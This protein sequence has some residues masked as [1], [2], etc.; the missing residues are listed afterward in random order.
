[1]GQNYSQ[2]SSDERYRISYL[3]KEGKTIRQI[4]A[5][6][7]RS[8]S[9]ISRE[10]KRNTFKT[11]GYD[12]AYAQQHTA[13]RRW[14]GSRLERQPI[15]RSAVLDNLAM[16][17]SPE[18]TAGRLAR[19]QGCNVISYE[20]IYRFID[21]QIRRTKDY[22][23]RL[24]LPRGKS[25]RGWRGRKGGSS[26][27]F[28]KNRISIHDRP[29]E[30]LERKSPGHWEADLMSFSK[31]G[32][33][34]LVAHERFSRM[35]MLFKL[36]NK[37]AKTVI[38]QL[39]N[40]FNSLPPQLKKTVSFDN[41]TEFAEHYQLNEI[42]VKTYFCDIKSP[43]QKGGVENSIGRLRRYLPRKTDIEALT[44]QD[45]ERIVA[46]YNHT[47]RKCLNYETPAEVLVKQLLHFKCEFT[48][49]PSPGRRPVSGQA[50]RKRHSHLSHPSVTTLV[51]GNNICHSRRE[52]QLFSL[53]GH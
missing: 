30:V 42:G 26:I 37:G 51:S 4:A 14:R 7:A 36:K 29:S 17:W 32:H 6:L 28:I 2:L 45:I 19:E 48:S 46:R 44:E 9:T 34:I 1:M 16:G 3:Q 8:S 13:G 41:G 40:L 24:F 47:P 23:W 27:S 18:L 52:G 38:S 12:A 22:S 5:A 39:T 20:S 21:T 31:Y 10:I 49:R 15:L 35:T 53:T 11:R 25:R 33:S 43:W 50:R